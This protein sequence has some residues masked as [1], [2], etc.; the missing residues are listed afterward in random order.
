MQTAKEGIKNE[1]IEGWHK[2]KYWHWLQS[3]GYEYLI[4]AQKFPARENGTRKTAPS[5]VI[6]YR[7]PLRGEFRVRQNKEVGC[8]L[9]KKRAM[10]LDLSQRTKWAEGEGSKTTHC[11]RNT[12]C[13]MMM[14]QYRSLYF[15]Q[16]TTFFIAYCARL[17]GNQ[18]E[19]VSVHSPERD[20]RQIQI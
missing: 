10:V 18:D 3:K 16:Q 17:W 1:Y 8:D 4:R 9:C 12:S 2:T 5:L 14:K 19:L 7:W 15:L 11:Y 6:S 20:K 13:V